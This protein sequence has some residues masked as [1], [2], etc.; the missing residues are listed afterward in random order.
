MASTIKSY[1]SGVLAS[2]RMEIRNRLIEAI[3]RIIQL[4]NAQPGDSAP[5]AISVPWL[6]STQFSTLSTSRPRFRLGTAQ[7]Y[8]PHARDPNQTTYDAKTPR[9]RWM[10][11]D[12]LK[13]AARIV[14][15][16]RPVQLQGLTTD[17]QQSTGHGV[18]R[19]DATS[20]Y[21]PSWH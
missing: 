5:L 16:T 13:K 8:K 11:N 6:S 20:S 15:T 1:W 19:I 2:I 18:G 14:S 10:E 7:S 21:P 3:N 17:I 4:A 12:I 9:S